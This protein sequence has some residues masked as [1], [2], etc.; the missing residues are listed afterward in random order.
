MSGSPKYSTVRMGAAYAAREAAQRRRREEQRRAREKRRAAERARLARE[1]AARRERAR[2]E[3]ERRRAALA[4]KE[5]ERAAGRAAERDAAVA[6]A[7]AEQGRV[8]ERG[9]DE[10]RDLLAGARRSGAGAGAEIE[11]LE[12]QLARLRERAAGG[13]R[14]GG[15]VEELR[16]RVVNLSPAAAGDGP[17]DSATVLAGLER[18][19]SA[20]GTD[21]AALDPDGHRRCTELLDQLRAAAA[22]DR[23]IR[24]EALRGTAEHA[25]TRHASVVAQAREAARQESAEAAAAA[26]EAERERAAAAER[27]RAE[28]AERERVAALEL[29]LAE[30]GERLGA[31]RAP[32]QGVVDTAAEL[33]DPG[34]GDEIGDA[35]GRATEALAAR[36]ASAALAA[37]AEVEGLL[38]DAERRLD[39]LELAY[40]RRRDLVEALRDAMTDEGFAF[41]GGEDEG[42]SFRL[43]F[44][45]PTG[46]TYETTVASEDDG[47][48]LLVYHVD[49]E[50]DVT[51]YAP[52][53]EPVCDATEA[54]LERVH[55]ALGG[56]EGFVPD[57]LSWDGK[58]PPDRRARTLPHDT[59]RRQAP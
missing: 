1:A 3:A 25:L 51:L 21:G 55:G 16:G 4:R 40:Q 45:R 47:T 26:E 10:V 43:H 41:E 52:Q 22:P 23:Q 15:A 59:S 28:E 37:V 5:A 19:L 12:G 14:L 53:D 9:L 58:P 36:S 56:A 42:G 50:R 8:D 6:R 27:E 11:A 34:I 24:F 33:G 7:R 30:A 54:L 29:A 2:A 18:R 57:G 38:P 20:V 46:A 49:G 32:A 13:G 35:L 48:P 44:T 17:Q 31:V 39:E